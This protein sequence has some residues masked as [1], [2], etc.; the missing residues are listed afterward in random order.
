MNED[1]ERETLRSKKGQRK[2]KRCVDISGGS[3]L[4]LSPSSFVV[5]VVV[6]VL[7]LRR[8]KDCKKMQ[9]ALSFSSFASPL[10]LSSHLLLSSQG[11]FGFVG[12]STFL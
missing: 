7:L 11:T 3:S 6:V 4:M 10:S 5:V 9:P 1:A 2:R 12:A 8:L